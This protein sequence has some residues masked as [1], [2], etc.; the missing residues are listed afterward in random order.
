MDRFC[1]WRWIRVPTS[2]NKD[3]NVDLVKKSNETDFPS[4]EQLL[5]CSHRTPQVMARKLETVVR[6]ETKQYFRSAE[7]IWE[8]SGM[9]PA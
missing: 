8:L 4:P 9:V 7:S 6:R 1:L 2:K 5:L 3:G